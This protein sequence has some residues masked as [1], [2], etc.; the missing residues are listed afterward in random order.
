MGVTL[1]SLF[2]T[3]IEGAGMRNLR[4]WAVLSA[5]I[6]VAA[7]V[8]ALQSGVAYAADARARSRSRRAM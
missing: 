7:P 1:A 8:V 6:A 4:V 5:A 2:G 3:L